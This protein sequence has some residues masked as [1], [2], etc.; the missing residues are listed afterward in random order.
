MAAREPVARA[1]LI[2]RPLGQVRSDMRL[3]RPTSPIHVVCRAS[4]RGL[5]NHASRDLV[6]LLWAAHS[7]CLTKHVQ[8]QDDQHPA[9]G[10]RMLDIYNSLDILRSSHLGHSARE[11][12]G[13]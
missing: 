4:S 8:S 7:V 3:G 13:T 9:M 5:G 2:R 11:S 10:R 6:I 12:A 1:A